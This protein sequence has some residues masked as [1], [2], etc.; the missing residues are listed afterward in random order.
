MWSLEAFLG[1]FSL[2][3]ARMWEAVAWRVFENDMDGA[4][5]TDLGGC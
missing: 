4:D 1:S 3:Q 2:C 5:S